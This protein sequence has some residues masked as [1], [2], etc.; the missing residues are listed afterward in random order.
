MNQQS[1][2]PLRMRLGRLNQSLGQHLH[3]F[4]QAL[5]SWRNTWSM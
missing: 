4:K 5:F 3:R 1:S 2:S